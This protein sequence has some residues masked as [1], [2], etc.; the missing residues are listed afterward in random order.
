MYK[1]LKILFSIFKI[2]GNVILI[3]PIESFLVYY[4]IKGHTYLGLKK[5]NHFSNVIKD[6]LEIWETLNRTV[7]NRK[8]LELNKPHSL[9]AV[10]NEIFI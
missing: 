3:N 8:E 6:N 10:V 2:G 4:I 7:K 9:G 5:I 1:Q